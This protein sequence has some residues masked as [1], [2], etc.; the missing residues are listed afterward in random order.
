VTYVNPLI[1][2]LLVALVGVLPLIV[3]LAIVIALPEPPN[4]GWD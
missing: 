4:G 1:R 2:F 3:A